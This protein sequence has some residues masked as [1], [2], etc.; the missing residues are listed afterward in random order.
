MSRTS[1]LARSPLRWQR[2]PAA[3]NP[4][5]AV[6]IY[7]EDWGGPGAPVVFYTGFMDPIEVAQTSELAQAL[8]EEF[9]LIFADHRGHGRSGK[10]HE[11]AAYALPTRVRDH[12]AVLDE[13]GL[14]RAHVIGFSWGARLGFAIG[15][16]APE[17]VRSLVLCG[18]QPYEWD[19]STP[20]A[21]AVAA[22]A[23]ASIGAGMEGFVPAFEAGLG[24]RFPE[25]ARSLELQND[26][27]AIRAAWESVFAEGAISQDLSDWRVPCLIYVGQADEMH[28]AA[29]RAADEIPS[30]TFLSLPA[31]TR[32]LLRARGP[33]GIGPDPPAAASQLSVVRRAG[34]VLY[35]LVGRMPKEGEMRATSMFKEGGIQ[36]V[37]RTYRANAQLGDLGACRRR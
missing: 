17:R 13:L 28:D 8:R 4:V 12:T 19:L 35:F 20:V 2:V 7:F 37:N 6:P 30:A 29:R 14:E 9:R 1:G 11:P 3:K 23:E 27:L 25:P 36:L 10:P 31:H 33:A 26:P 22:G 15:E 16:L 21:N 32:Y 24:L 34:H 18:N 5:D